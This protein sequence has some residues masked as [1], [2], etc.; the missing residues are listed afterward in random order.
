MKKTPKVKNCS[1]PKTQDIPTQPWD[2][3]T[4]PTPQLRFLCLNPYFFFSFHSD[5]FQCGGDWNSLAGNRDELWLL[6]GLIRK[7]PR[8]HPGIFL[9]LQNR[10]RKCPAKFLMWTRGCK[11][12]QNPKKTQ[13]NQ[14]KKNVIQTSTHELWSKQ[15]QWGSKALGS[16]Q[17]LKIE[18]EDQTLS[19]TRELKPLEYLHLNVL[20]LLKCLALI[21]PISTK[22]KGFIKLK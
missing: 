19:W 7:T 3:S 16:H 12:D 5:S 17:E 1:P 2:S 6:S 4:F 10:A 13:P 14:Q 9:V 11:K 21:S 15:F 8:Q 18:R 20:V 22:S